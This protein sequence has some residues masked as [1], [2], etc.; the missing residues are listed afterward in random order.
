MTIIWTSNLIPF[1]FNMK[2]CKKKKLPVI[3]RWIF[4]EAQTGKRKLVEYFSFLNVK[5]KSFVKDDNDIVVDDNIA[6]GTSSLAV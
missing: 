2:S 6:Q 4:T 3:S 5:L 1:I